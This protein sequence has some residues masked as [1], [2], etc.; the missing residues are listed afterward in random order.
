[1][2]TVTQLFDEKIGAPENITQALSGIK[3]GAWMGE[4]AQ[5]PGSAQT[6]AVFYHTR[7]DST[8]IKGN[9]TKWYRVTV[10]HKAEKGQPS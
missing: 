1:M 5:F 8:Y 3:S 7:Y 10:R 4:G 9:D 2:G 6:G